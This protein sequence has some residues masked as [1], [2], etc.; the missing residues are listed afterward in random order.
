M[1]LRGIFIPVFMAILFATTAL[2]AP[3]QDRPVVMDLSQWFLSHPMPDNPGEKGERIFQSNRMSLYVSQA[4][5]GTRLEFRFHKTVDEV[6]D[7]LQA[8][9]RRRYW[10]TNQSLRENSVTGGCT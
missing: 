9:Y 5:A 6:T 10:A 2:A 7:H 8:N 1:T 4:S 3:T